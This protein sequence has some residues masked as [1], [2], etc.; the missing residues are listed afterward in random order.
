MAGLR[1]SWTLGFEKEGSIATDW[2]FEHVQTQP[3]LLV[4]SCALDLPEEILVSEGTWGP[5]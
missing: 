3:E 1:E 2:D 4:S 5:C